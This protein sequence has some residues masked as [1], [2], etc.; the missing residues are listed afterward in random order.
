MRDNYVQEIA[1]RIHA[2]V[3]PEKMPEEN[4]RLLFRI[5]A[6]LAIAKGEDVTAEDVHAAWAA[7]MTGINPEHPALRAYADLGREEIASD[8]PYVE[9]I[10][11]A[12]RQ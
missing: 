4:S 11:R 5:Y 1:N 10:R 7:W 2:D 8:L 3:S 6:V 9:A 12:A